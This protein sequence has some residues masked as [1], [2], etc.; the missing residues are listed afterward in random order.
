MKANLEHYKVFY[1][2]A[3]EGGITA[4]AAVLF[5]S[6]PA[7]SKAIKHL[8]DSLE[9]SLFFRG[10]RGMTLTPE[11]KVLYQ[12]VARAFKQ[13]SLGEKQVAEMVDMQT[14]AVRL[15]SSD[16]LSRCFTLPFLEA[17]H[18]KYPDIH[19]AVQNG[20]T[21]VIEQ[22]LEDEQIAIAIVAS[23]VEPRE[24]FMVEAISP[25]QDIFVAGDKYRFLAEKKQALKDLLTLPIICTEKSTATRQYLDRFFREQQLTLEPSFELGS[26]DLVPLYTAKNLGIGLATRQGVA[27]QLKSGVLTEIPT[28]IAIPQRKVCIVTRGDGHL[29][30]AE[31][32][33]L[34]MLQNQD[35]LLAP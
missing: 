9:C 22:A 27:D 19:I 35:I 25:I 3:S 33:F 24:S 26:I 12:Y 2:V 4:A 17:F 20:P 8:E 29:S 14:G 28:D 7:V 18:E 21:P 31:Q 34:A 23:P 13:L 15:G 5:V 10:P 32:S 30:Q 16:M 11:G 1:H 6:Q